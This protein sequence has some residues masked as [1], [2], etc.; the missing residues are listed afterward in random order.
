MHALIPQEHTDKNCSYLPVFFLR[1]A[2]SG[3]T[4]TCEVLEYWLTL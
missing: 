2:F 3:N 1:I 4:K